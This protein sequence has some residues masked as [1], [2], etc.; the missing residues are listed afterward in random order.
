[1]QPES[2][3]LEAGG[4]L[5]VAAFKLWLLSLGNLS[6]RCLTD[7]TKEKTAA[8]Y[9][10]TQVPLI[11]LLPD[12]VHDFVVGELGNTLAAHLHDK[13]ILAKSGSTRG[14]IR[15]DVVDFEDAPVVML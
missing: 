1:M 5:N 13:V 3:G 12:Q 8:S 7:L 9:Q 4:Q 10:Q 6:S 14:R 11:P 15:F 2:E